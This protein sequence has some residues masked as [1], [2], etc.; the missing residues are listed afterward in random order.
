LRYLFLLSLI[1]LLAA[2][3]GDRGLPLRGGPV[4]DGGPLFEV[5]GGRGGNGGGDGDAASAATYACG[6]PQGWCDEQQ[7]SPPPTCATPEVGSCPRTPMNGYMIT[8]CRMG[9][10]FTRWYYYLRAYVDG[11][12]PGGFPLGFGPPAN[13]QP[14][15]GGAP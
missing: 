7:G 5:G 13:C 4:F 2:A 8:G 3:C 9:P 12:P 1:L 14:V 10:G 15:D 6:S 11:G